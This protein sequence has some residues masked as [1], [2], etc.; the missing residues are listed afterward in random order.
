MHSCLSTCNIQ[1]A[2]PALLVASFLT[3]DKSR[4]EIG[5]GSEAKDMIKQK[6][7]TEKGPMV[8]QP[9]TPPSIPRKH[10]RNEEN[11]ALGKESLKNS[12]FPQKKCLVT[13]SMKMMALLYLALW[14]T[15]MP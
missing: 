12:H 10:F 5:F 15:A 13:R 2:L 14:G 9:P 7:L 6:N 11:R 1:L 4:R 3:Y 8:C